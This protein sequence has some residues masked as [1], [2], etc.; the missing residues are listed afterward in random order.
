[1]RGGAAFPEG[2]FPGASEAA[3]RELGKGPA[4]APRKQGFPTP[5]ST[6]VQKLGL[7]PRAVLAGAARLGG[8]YL[9]LIE[10]VN[11]AGG[12]PFHDGEANALDYVCEQFAEFVASR[13]IIFDADVVVGA[14]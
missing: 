13:P 11:P 3:A 1:M 4:R 8:R 5:A 10:L 7:A 12:T 2:C 6:S 9:G 14:Q